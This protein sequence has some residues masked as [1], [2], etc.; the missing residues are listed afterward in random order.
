MTLTRLPLLLCALLLAG[1]AGTATEFECNATTS[2]N[3]MTMGQANELARKKTQ[4]AANAGKP[5]A[6]ALPALVDLP[7]APQHGTTMATAA[8]T[9]PVK[10]TPAPT[11][12]ATSSV[13][14]P[15]A[16][17]SA[18]TTPAASAPLAPRALF[19]PTAASVPL[20]TDAMCSTP[21]CDTL[22]E[23]TP[24]RLTDTI[25]TL[26]IAP[27]IDSADQFHQPGRVS[28]VLTPGTWQLPQQLN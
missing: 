20:A 4:S 11:A 16:T 23:A 1:C 5:G 26:W 18:S 12:P 3:C 24:L 8:P 9:T 13:L 19:T 15:V 2:D 28:F 14:A 7:A 10:A 21:R 27:W 17:S 25:A 22:G 6:G